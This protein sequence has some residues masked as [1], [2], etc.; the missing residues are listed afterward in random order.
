MPDPYPTV[1]AMSKYD[2]RAAC[3]P[4]ASGCASE[5]DRAGLESGGLGEEGNGLTHVEN[6][7]SVSGE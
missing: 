2:G 7:V 3:E 1:I 4:D 5:N 6:L